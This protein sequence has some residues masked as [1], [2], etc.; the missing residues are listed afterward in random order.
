MSYADIAGLQYKYGMFA[1]FMPVM[2][3]ALMGTSKQLAVGPVA[4]VSLLVNAGLDGQLTEKQCPALYCPDP[5]NTTTCYPS[6]YPELRLPGEEPTAVPYECG[7][8]YAKLAFILSFLVGL[9]QLGAGILR[10]G[11]LVAFLGHPVVSG[12]TS[13]AA[14]IIGLSQVKYIV[15]FDIA[16]SQYVYVTLGNLF[17][18]IKKLKYMPFILG[19][20]WLFTL[21]FFQKGLRTIPEESLL[22]DDEG[23][24]PTD[25]VY[26]WHCAHARS[27]CPQKRIQRRCGRLHPR[28]CGRHLVSRLGHVAVA[29]A[30]RRSSVDQRDRFHGV[31]LD[32]Q[33][34]RHPAWLRSCR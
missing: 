17:G 24:R 21:I 3:Y 28:R 30:Y 12:F 1:G 26:P 33:G 27:A 8:Q 7:A 18:N 10:A 4:M 19:L 6:K 5:G 22:Q 34:P 13:G 25:D 15:G 31:D 23:P 9:I 2:I 20:I 11:Y 16:K 32:R 29:S 14:V